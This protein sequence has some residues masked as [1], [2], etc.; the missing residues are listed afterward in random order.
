MPGSS[1]LLSFLPVFLPGDAFFLGGDLRADTTGTH[2]LRLI[3]PRVF[4][5]AVG[6]WQTALRVRAEEVLRIFLWTDLEMFEFVM[7]LA[8]AG[9]MTR[10]RG[11]R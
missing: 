3:W 6:V 4:L 7:V 2:S 1:S 9:T 10:I 5:V 8:G 11:G